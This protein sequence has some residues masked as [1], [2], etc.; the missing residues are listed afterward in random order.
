MYQL[1]AEDLSHLGGPMGSEYTTE[2]FRR[3]FTTLD[4]A[5]EAANRHYN[6]DMKRGPIKWEKDGRGVT[7]GD[8]SWVM[9]T[10]KL[11]KAEA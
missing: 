5:K 8:L 10:I 7:S 2:M 3:F 6:R 1:I 4:K 11:V 9:Y